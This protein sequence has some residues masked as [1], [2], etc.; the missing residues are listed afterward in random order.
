VPSKG[1]LYTDGL[2][3]PDEDLDA[4]LTVDPDELRTQLPQ[5][6]QHLAMFGDRL[7]REVRAQLDALKERLEES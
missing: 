1:D 7:P 4:V 3:V 5:V 2:D 6:E